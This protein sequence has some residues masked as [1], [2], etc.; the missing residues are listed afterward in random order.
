MPAIATKDGGID[1]FIHNHPFWIETFNKQKKKS[2]LEM[3]TPCFFY[4]RNPS[5]TFFVKPSI[6]L[7]LDKKNHWDSGACYH[8]SLRFKT[9]Y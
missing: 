4:Y 3:L 9:T 2:N 5:V 6:W 8:H 7:T 1:G